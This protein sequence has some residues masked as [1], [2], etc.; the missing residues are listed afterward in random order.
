MN[1]PSSTAWS[2]RHAFAQSALPPTTKHVL[3]TLG[4]FMNEF[5]EGCYPSV[6]DICRYSGLDKKTVI[7]HLATARDEGWIAVSQHGYRGQR[8]KRQEY[9]ARWPERDLVA[10]CAPVDNSEGGGAVPPPSDDKVVELVPE[11]GGIE[12]SKVVEQLHQDKTSPITTPD[13][14]PV[15]SAQKRA[16]ENSKSGSDEKQIERWLKRH[17]PIWPSYITDSGPK[18]LKAALA[19][20]EDERQAAVDRLQDYVANA[21]VGGRT[22]ICTF[23]VYLS[24]KRWEKLPPAMPKPFDEYATPFSKPWGAWILGH[25][26]TSEDQAAKGWPML[27]GLYRM[28]SSKQGHRFA[29]RWHDLGADFEPVPVGSPM[30]AAWQAHFAQMG[31]PWFPDPGDQPVVFFPKGGPQGLEAFKAVVAGEG[32]EHDGGRREAAE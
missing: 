23:G 31:W 6:A 30:F 1:A 27:T 17:H 10:S 20:T 19:L 28:A 5:G 12:G 11:G 14:S 25:L 24:E 18:A 22:M 16:R 21:T 15:G 8:W 2:W 7:K 9:T 26:L 3:H 29:K 13:T 4:M 32:G